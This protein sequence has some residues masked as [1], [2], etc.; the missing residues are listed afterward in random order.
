MKLIVG[1]GNPGR[2]Y[3]DTRHNVGFM[4]IDELAKRHG[5]G[6]NKKKFQGHFAYELLGT[7][8]VILLEP[9]TYMNLSGDSV[10][11]LVDFYEIAPEDIVVVYDDLD[12]PTG[13]VRLRQ[14]GGHGGHNGIRSMI[15]QLGTKNF[16]R[17]R[18]GIDRPKEGLTVTDHVLGRFTKS[19]RQLIDQS[20]LHAA[21]A[22]EAFI[23]EDFQTVMNKYN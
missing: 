4:V 19:E 16:N 1:L 21:Q 11:P 13:K 18:I 2:K 17:V 5:W 12:L 23:T 14:N 8:K 20:I 7:D 9:Q 22:C 10:K 3:K 15:D 6:L